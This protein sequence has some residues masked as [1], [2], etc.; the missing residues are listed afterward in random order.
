MAR[1]TLIL[2]P[3]FI[4]NT[5][6][7]VRVSDINYGG[8]LGND[9]VLTLLHEARLQFFKS[10][11]YVSEVILENETGLVVADSVVVYKAEAFHGDLL[12]IHLAAY[13][14]NA[15]GMDLFYYVCNKDNG[16]EIA[17]AKTGIVCVNYKKKKVAK[18]PETFIKQIREL[19]GYTI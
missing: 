3:E 6:I 1:V 16:Q 4:F 12:E 8:H 17:R 7:T 14:F 13:D 11:G 19:E 2:P 10:L 15:Y 18:A 9:A 5:L